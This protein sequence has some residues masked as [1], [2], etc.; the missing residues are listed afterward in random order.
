MPNF[1]CKITT[2]G[3]S[4]VEETLTADSKESL[5]KQ[6]E[7]D[8]KFVLDI[9]KADGFGAFLKKAKSHR[10]RFKIKDFFSFN[11]EF[12]VLIKAGLPIVAALD[13]IIEQDDKSQLNT[14]LKDVRDNISTGET[15]SE[16]F[17]KYAN[18]FS[19][20][21]ISSLQTGEKSGDLPT[22]ILRYILI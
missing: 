11:Q 20:L 10:K 21:Y 8:G 1:R 16:A 15:L 7:S 13:S 18:L 12:L 2:H 22:A 17:G 9:K 5:I 14:I 4:V 6:L 19:N 3:G